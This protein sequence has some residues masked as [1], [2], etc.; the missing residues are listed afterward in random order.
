MS[1][2]A[3]QCQGFLY[4]DETRASRM[5]LTLMKTLANN[6]EKKQEQE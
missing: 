6:E 1:D 2:R 4:D 3:I 5:L